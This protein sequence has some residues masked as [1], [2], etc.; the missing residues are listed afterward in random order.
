ME[1]K[2][3]NYKLV[4]KCYGSLDASPLRVIIIYN[5]YK[6]IFGQ[7]FIWIS[8]KTQSFDPGLDLH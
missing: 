4:E 1:Q 5:K 8:N 6:E 7:W 2:E 3:L